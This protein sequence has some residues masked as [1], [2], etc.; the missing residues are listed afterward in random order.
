MRRNV[1][2]LSQQLNNLLYLQEYRSNPLALIPLHLHETVQQVLKRV[3]PRAAK[4]G[5][6][7]DIQMPEITP[8]RV[9]PS[10]LELVVANLLDNAIKYN[11]PGGQV[12]LSVLDEPERVI[13]RIEDTGSGI[14]A[15]MLD[16][17]FLPFYRIDNSL[18]GPQPGSGIGLALVQHV[19][20]AH[21]G[22]VIV[23][24]IMGE[25]SIFTVILPRK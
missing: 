23:R 3:Q 10:A 14:P 7:L 24:S 21:G 18:A 16:K 6:T 20:E 12:I 25:G 9:D 22:Q 1:E 19:V 4:A 15:A 2:T 17:I 5:V 8:I 11:V 13:M